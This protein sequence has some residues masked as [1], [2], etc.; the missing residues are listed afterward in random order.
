MKLEE[1]FRKAVRGPLKADTTTGMS[2]SGIVFEAKHV[3]PWKDAQDV[4]L[5][6]AALLVHCFNHFQELVDALEESNRLLN[7]VFDSGCEGNPFG[8]DHNNAI[9]AS[10]ASELLLAKVKEVKV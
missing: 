2:A 6:N 1:A 4:A 3:P 8:K 5:V 9:D 10:G 7:V